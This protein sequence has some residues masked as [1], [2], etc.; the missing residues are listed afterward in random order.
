MRFLIIYGVVL[1]RGRVADVVVSAAKWVIL[2][3]YGERTCEIE[4]RRAC[5]LFLFDLSNGEMEEG[6][7]W[8][9]M[10]LFNMSISCSNLSKRADWL[11]EFSLSCNA[12]LSNL[13]SR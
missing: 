5:G 8:G 4:T 3:D 12:M 6:V 1:V 13:A 10:A 7:F 11:N 2:V 9:T